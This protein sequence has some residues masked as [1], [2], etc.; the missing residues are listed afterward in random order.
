MTPLRKL[1]IYLA[2]VLATFALFPSVAFADDAQP[3]NP[4]DT[5]AS[6]RLS[7]VVVQAIVAVFLPLIVGFVTTLADSSLFKGLLQLVLNAISAFIV[8]YTMIDGSVVFSKQT[9]VVFAVGCL[10]SMVAY[11]NV[12]KA[13]GITSSLV[14]TTVTSDPTLGTTVVY[15][16]GVLAGVGRT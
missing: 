13:K 2:G 11:Y 6:V 3:I 4:T 10:S 12:W 9:V 7:A 5:L 16:P 15:A 14:T 8:Q 1:L